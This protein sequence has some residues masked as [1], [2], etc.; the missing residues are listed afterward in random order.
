[1]NKRD[2]PVADRILLSIL[3]K[4]YGDKDD[5]DNHGGDDDDLEIL[6]DEAPPSYTCNVQRAIAVTFAI[7]CCYFPD[8]ALHI[9]VSM[10][11]SCSLRKKDRTRIRHGRRTSDSSPIA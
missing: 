2:I 9:L 6:H 11:Q 3:W 10:K 1:V 5:N 4:P 7:N 8:G